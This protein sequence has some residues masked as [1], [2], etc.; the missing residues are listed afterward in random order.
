MVTK[1]HIEK[2]TV[3]LL[4]S[5]FIQFSAIEIRWVFSHAKLM[6]SWLQWLEKKVGC[7]CS[8]VSYSHFWTNRA[9]YQGKFSMFFCAHKNKG[10]D[11]RCDKSLRHVAATGCCNKSPRLHCCCDKSLALVLSLWSVARIQTGLN[12]CDISQRQNKGKRLVAA[13]V[14]TRQLVAAMYRRDLSHRVS[15]P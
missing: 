2:T 3:Y 11:T 7:P 8:L 13:T 5:L 10:R 14:Q 9:Q 4:F 1:R 15:R 12:S 6:I